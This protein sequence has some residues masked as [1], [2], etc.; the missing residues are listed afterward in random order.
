[1][2]FSD[3]V[4]AYGLIVLLLLAGAVTAI[5]PSVEAEYRRQF[6]PTTLQVWVTQ[7]GVQC[8]YRVQTDG[9]RDV[10]A[11]PVDPTCGALAPRRKK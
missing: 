11:T 8:E 10:I 5:L 6:P 4:R 1:M 3:N 2:T 7:G 9:Y